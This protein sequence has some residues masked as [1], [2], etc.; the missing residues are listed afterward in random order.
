MRTRVGRS[1]CP[2]VDQCARGSTIDSAL[3]ARFEICQL[4]LAAGRLF[5][6]NVKD[7]DPLEGRGTDQL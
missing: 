3:S 4:T 5:A 1:C 2:T 6:M 7:S